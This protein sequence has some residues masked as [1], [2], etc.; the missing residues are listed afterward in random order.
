MKTGNQQDVLI[1]TS[2]APF[3]IEKQKLAVQTWLDLGFSVV[4]LNIKDEID[5]LQ[6]VFEGVA[7]YEVKRDARERYGKPFVYV[8]DILQYL[9]E[10]DVE[11]CGIVNS[12]IQIR[13]AQDF[14]SYIY[15]QAKGS[16]V[17]ASRIDIDSAESITGEMY[18]YGFDMFFF[19]RD[20]L[21]YFPVCDAFCLG[22]PWWDYWVPCIALKK[23]LNPKYLQ[24]TVAYHIQHPINYSLKNW[25]EVGIIFTEFFK[26]EITHTLQEL[27]DNGKLEDLDH[28]LGPEITY[29]FIL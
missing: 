16:T 19:D 29:N 13:A 25:R 18:G 14:V 15:D 21:Q 7:F 6:S 17:F 12:D 11:V 10:C 26:P 9:Q 27:L 8:N 4:S 2:I 28:Q 23:S 24:D 1:A 3:S 22:I 20:L 5:K